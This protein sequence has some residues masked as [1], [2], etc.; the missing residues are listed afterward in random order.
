MLMVFCIAYSVVKCLNVRKTVDLVKT[1]ILL[2]VL[3]LF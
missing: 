3:D 1:S 2:F